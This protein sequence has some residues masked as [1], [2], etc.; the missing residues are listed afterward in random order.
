MDRETAYLIEKKSKALKHCEKL[1]K[2]IEKNGS[3][4][5][6]LNCTGVEF[7]I[8]KGDAFYFNIQKTKFKLLE[9]IS[10]IEVLEKNKEK[11]TKSVPRTAPAPVGASSAVVA[12]IQTSIFDDI[13]EQKRQ[14]K[15]EYQRKWNNENREKKRA[16]DRAY[17][18]RKRALKKKN[19]NKT[20]FFLVK[21][22]TIINKARCLYET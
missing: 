11:V 9:E 10:S 6:K 12:G 15:L 18:A 2:R 21:C 8:K 1:L 16:S 7:T 4:T 5:I 20:W 13:K 22:G 17:Q 3:A 14:K 19:W